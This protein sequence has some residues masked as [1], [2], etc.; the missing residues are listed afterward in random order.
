MNTEKIIQAQQEV[1]CEPS[2]GVGGAN[3]NINYSIKNS[4]S[5]NYKTKIIGKL[6]GN[7]KDKKVEIAV[8]LNHL[9]NF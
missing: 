2:S 6:E 1:F 5:F 3:N 7:I 9:R 8:P 4:K